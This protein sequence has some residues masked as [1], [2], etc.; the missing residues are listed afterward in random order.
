M[1]SALSTQHAAPCQPAADV[2]P[3][4]RRR[5]ARTGGWASQYVI[6]AAPP[7]WAEGDS[8][9]QRPHGDSSE[10]RPQIDSRLIGTEASSLIS[11]LQAT[12]RNGGL[13]STPRTGGL[14]SSLDFLGDY[15]ERRPQGDSSGD[16]QRGGLRAT[17]QAPPSTDAPLPN[18]H[19]RPNAQ[20]SNPR[21]AS[22][23]PLPGPCSAAS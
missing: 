9:E 19:R 18:G 13:R 7:P 17:S 8:S 22:F 10:R 1:S 2:M 6:P 11:T 12:P 20:S 15:S 5:V 3:V 4:R 16:Y 23:P 14:R 21:S